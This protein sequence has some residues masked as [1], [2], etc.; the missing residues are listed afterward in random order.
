M[1]F[2][3]KDTSPQTGTQ[4]PERKF[5]FANISDTFHNE[6]FLFTGGAILTVIAVFILGAY[7]SFLFNGG[8]D[9]SVVESSVGEIGN[10]TGGLGASL[11][12]G[13]RSQHDAH[14]PLQGRTMVRQL[15]IPDGLAVRIPTPHS[16]GREQV[17]HNGELFHLSR[18]N[19]RHQC[20]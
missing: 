18:R 19:T 8:N 16:S 6:T 5:S 11:A 17:R 12:N 10:T 9:Q 14:N 2:K 1:N 4:K 3:K 13:M 15:Y 7:I 20:Y